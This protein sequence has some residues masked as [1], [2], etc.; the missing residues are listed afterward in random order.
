M[1][2]RL[3]DAMMPP[4]AIDGVSYQLGAGIGSATYH[5]DAVELGALLQVADAAMYEAKRARRAA[6]PPA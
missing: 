4:I 1:C 2:S 3:R 5:D 6:R